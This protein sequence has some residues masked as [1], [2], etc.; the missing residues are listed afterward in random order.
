[1]ENSIQENKTAIKKKTP[2]Q[3]EKTIQGKLNKRLS[4]MCLMTQH[5][6]AEE[7]QPIVGIYL[8]QEGARLNGK[9]KVNR[10]IRWNVG[11]AT[12]HVLPGII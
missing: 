4:E 11:D 6:L 3:L 9:I 7:N 1:M 10:M 2:E 8:E 12:I 5:H